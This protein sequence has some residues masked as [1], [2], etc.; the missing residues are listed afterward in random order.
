MKLEH[1]ERAAKLLER[2]GY[3]SAF[4]I[5]LINMG[6]VYQRWRRQDEARRC[7]ERAIATDF[8]TKSAVD[9]GV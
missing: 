8:Y 9:A 5:V 2:T 7:L 6:T 1:F 4:A 3:A